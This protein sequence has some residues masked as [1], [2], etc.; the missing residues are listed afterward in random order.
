MYS[1]AVV[2]SVLYLLRQRF[3]YSCTCTCIHVCTCSIVSVGVVSVGPR[4]FPHMHKKI[5][6]SSKSEGK[7]LD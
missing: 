2:V 1:S 4:L 3:R 5:K 7:G 6:G